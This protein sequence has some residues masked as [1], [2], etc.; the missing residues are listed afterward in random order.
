MAQEYA[1]LDKAAT[2]SEAYLKSRYQH[3]EGILADV[4]NATH[5]KEV[6]N[7][8]LQEEIATLQAEI[9]KSKDP[10]KDNV[11]FELQD[12]QPARMNRIMK[13]NRMVQKIKDQQ[14]LL[15]K[16]HDQ[17]DSYMHRSFPSLG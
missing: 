14:E 1:I 17:L 13:R 7:S 8:Q 4:K 15:M 9:E 16:L 6:E 10:K 12:N 5:E 2:A 11:M 3:L